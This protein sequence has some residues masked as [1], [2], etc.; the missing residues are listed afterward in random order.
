MG[1][2]LEAASAS[3]L[4]SYG[5]LQRALAARWSRADERLASALREYALVRH[6]AKPGDPVWIAAQLKVAEARLRWREC[7]EHVERLAELLEGPDLF[8]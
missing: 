6:V 7:A 4:S 1:Y 5:G 8:R 3:S 2:E